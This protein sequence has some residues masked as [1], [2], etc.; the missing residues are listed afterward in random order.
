[1]E[2]PSANETVGVF[3]EADSR[4]LQSV[5]GLCLC[6]CFIS[7]TQRKEYTKYGKS[8]VPGQPTAL[9]P[10]SLETLQVK[11]L[12]E[13]QRSCFVG[14]ATGTDVWRSL[15]WQSFGL[16]R[17]VYNTPLQ[18]K[19]AVS[20]LLLVEHWQP[21]NKYQCNNFRFFQTTGEHFFGSCRPG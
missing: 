2:K 17:R 7:L 4:I 6:L 8:A 12:K 11:Y 9:D 10:F 19:S 3:K 20:Q 16:K 21:I 5:L 15:Q 1:M 14:P 18:L 13:A